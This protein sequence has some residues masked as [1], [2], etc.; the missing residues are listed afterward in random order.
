MKRTAYN[1]L[2]ALA[3]TFALATSAQGAAVVTY[4]NYTAVNA[5]DTSWIVTP[6][7]GTEIAAFNVGGNATSYGGVSWLSTFPSSGVLNTDTQID[8]YYHQPNVA[9]APTVSTFYSGGP[10]LLHDGAY[11]PSNTNGVVD[12]RG[13]TIG[14]DYLVQFVFADTRYD[15]GTM[16]VQ[17]VSGVTGNSTTATYSYTNGQYLVVNAQFKADTADTLWIPSANGGGGEQLN[18]IRIVAIPEP[19]AALLGGLGILGLLRRRR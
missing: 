4:T 13:F 1:T 6:A 14:Q 11:W 2:A 10:A 5:A 3:A 8:F 19:S 18:G 16:Q 17:A 9:W 7:G 15:G 12:L